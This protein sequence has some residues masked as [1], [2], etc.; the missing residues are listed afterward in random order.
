MYTILPKLRNETQSG[1]NI[2]RQI[3][4]A[5]LLLETVLCDSLI[6]VLLPSYRILTEKIVVPQKNIDT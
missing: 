2:R 6:A 5:Q 4:H 1:E 3:I